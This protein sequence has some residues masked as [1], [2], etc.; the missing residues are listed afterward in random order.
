MGRG[1]VE[2]NTESTIGNERHDFSTNTSGVQVL[3][4]TSWYATHITVPQNLGSYACRAVD[5]EVANMLK[6]VDSARFTPCFLPVITAAPAIIAA[7]ILLS[8]SLQ[9][10]EVF[11]P[12][13]TKPFVQEAKEKEDDL[14]PELRQHPLTAILTLLVIV[15]IGLALQI[16]TIFLPDRH[17]IEIYPS[18]AW[19]WKSTLL[20]LNY[21]SQ[22]W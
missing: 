9:I 17:I 13:W 1:S 5:D 14:A 7:L 10:F 19:V 3:G 18:L 2:I 12:R 21:G 20:T 11:R 4:T 8:Y 16:V 15:G 22:Y 6:D